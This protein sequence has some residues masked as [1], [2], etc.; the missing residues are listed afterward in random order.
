[1]RTTRI[2]KFVPAVTA[3]F[4]FT[5]CGGDDA[6]DDGFIDTP[7]ATAPATPADTP[8]ASMAAMSADFAPVDNSGASGTI[9][10]SESGSGTQIVAMLNGAGEGVHQG[11]IH[12]GTCAQPGSPVTPLEPVTT[13]ATGSGQATSTVDIPAST[14][15]NGQHIVM[16]HA[17]G[18]SPGAA[19]ACAAIPAHQM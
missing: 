4:L 1:M 13:D 16:Y 14:V 17:A 8:P 9:R 5:A 7:P 12:A 10:V 15:M 18:G 2:A 19:I 6:A 11:H 3:I